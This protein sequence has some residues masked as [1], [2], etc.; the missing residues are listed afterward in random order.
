MTIPVSTIPVVK[1]YLLAQMTV[2][3]SGPD[4]GVFYDEPGPGYPD[5]VIYLGG[6][7]QKLDPVQ[8]VG[9]GGEGWLY[10]S[11]H[12]V[13][14]VDV[15][16]GGDTPQI[17]FERACEIVGQI[18]A[19]IRSDPRLG[20]AIKVKAYPAGTEYESGWEENHTGRVTHATMRISV[21][22]SL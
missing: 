11:Y 1:S 2:A 22:T 19:L 14:E 10:E 16:R 4:V 21:E 18:E 5:D 6:T 8:M 3:L 15:Y 9:S 17:V 20:G 12:Q 13:I 7:E